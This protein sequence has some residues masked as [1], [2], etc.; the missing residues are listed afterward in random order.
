METDLSS[1][2]PAPERLPGPDDVRVEI[3]VRITT[4]SSSLGKVEIDTILPALLACH[5]LESSE[6]EVASLIGTRLIGPLR[7]CLRTELF[8]RHQ[9]LP[10]AWLDGIP[11]LADW[12][13]LLAHLLSRQGLRLDQNWGATVGGEPLTVSFLESL[14]NQMEG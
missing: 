7:A 2:D 14:G 6:T 8:R 3:S 11:G 5:R 4:G 9:S 12:Y 10:A 13:E 1:S